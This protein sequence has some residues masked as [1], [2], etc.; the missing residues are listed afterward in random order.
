ME[1]NIRQSGCINSIAKTLYN[2]EWRK[3]NKALQAEYAREWY[4]CNREKSLANATLWRLAN[5]ER[6]KEIKRKWY[7][8]HKDNYHMYVLKRRALLVGGEFDVGDW[9]E[10]Q[11]QFTGHCAYCWQQKPL[12]VDHV[13]PLSKGGMHTKAN[14]V[15]ACRSCNCSK[16]DK[17]VNLL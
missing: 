2:K 4:L 6:R 15:P 3:R 10:L 13:I 17:V 11:W 9:L 8:A 12:T 16:Q 5:P 7:E 14:I 1:G